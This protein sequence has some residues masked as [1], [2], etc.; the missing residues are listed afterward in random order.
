MLT[1]TSKVFMDAVCPYLHVPMFKFFG[2]VEPAQKADIQANAATVLAIVV[3]G[4]G[5]HFITRTEDSKLRSHGDSDGPEPLTPQTLKDNMIT[6]VCVFAPVINK[7]NKK[8]QFGQLW[9]YFIDLPS[10]ET[11]LYEYLLWQKA[12]KFFV[13]FVA[14][15]A[16]QHWGIMGIMAE[17]AKATTDT[18]DTTIVMAEDLANGIYQL[19]VNKL[20]IKCKICK[21]TTHCARDCPLAKVPRWQGPTAVNIYQPAQGTPQGQ[22]VP[23][24]AEPAEQACEVWC[25]MPRHGN[26]QGGHGSAHGTCGI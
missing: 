21:G 11:L 14:H 18:L 12:D 8:N 10:T 22:G 17:L 13:Y 2:N 20:V 15:L 1:P 5:Q 24:A 23:E 26:L 6:P 7:L 16:A 9:T 4:G 25:E 19:K 3:H